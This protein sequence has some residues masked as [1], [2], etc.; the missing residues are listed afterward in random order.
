MKPTKQTRQL[1]GRGGLN[2]LGKSQRTIADYSK[3]SPITPTEPNPAEVK[4]LS[5]PKGKR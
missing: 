1:P 4:I 5:V 3:A 2:D